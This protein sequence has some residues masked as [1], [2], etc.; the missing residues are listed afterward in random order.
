[1]EDL[2]EQEYKSHLPPPSFSTFF[3]SYCLLHVLRVKWQRNLKDYFVSEQYHA[4][5]GRVRDEIITEVLGRWQ[6]HE[7]LVAL[8]FLM[9][10]NG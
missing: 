9:L 4:S 3:S 1:M 6:I 8:L 10:R 2:G 5:A 7:I